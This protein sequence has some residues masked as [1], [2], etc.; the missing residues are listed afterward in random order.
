MIDTHC[1]IDSERFDADREEVLARAWTAGLTGLV[2]P[3]VGPESWDQLLELPRRQARIR[4]ALG[5]H[6]WLLPSLPEAAD[7]QHL[8]RLDQLLAGGGAIAVGECGLDGPSVARGASLQRQLRVFSGQLELARKHELPLL[9][10]CF[11]A[12]PA[13]VSL[14][15]ERAAPER[16]LLLHSYSGGAE[17]IRFY[18][19]RGCSFSF[20][21]PVTFSEGRRPIEAAT[22]VPL[23]RLMVETDAPDQPPHPHRGGRCEPSYLPLV[24]AALARA[25]G[26]GERELAALTA[27]NARRFFR[28]DFSR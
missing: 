8:Q 18:C 23:E 1:H 21:G 9:V 10:H 28:W 14:L 19:S 17:Q 5:I 4:V 3:A 15:R 26:L 11:R 20:A 27:E 16:G 22:V 7:E 12:H 24:L 25:H 13:L 2:V 6:P